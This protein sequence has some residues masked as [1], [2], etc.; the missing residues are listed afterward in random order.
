MGLLYWDDM[1]ANKSLVGQK[2]LSISKSGIR[3]IFR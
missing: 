2:Y 3:K 1:K